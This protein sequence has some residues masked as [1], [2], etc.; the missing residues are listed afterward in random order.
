MNLDQIKTHFN[1][2]LWE[3]LYSIYVCNSFLAKSTNERK[4]IHWIKELLPVT[5]RFAR[6][7][8]L[9]RLPASPSLLFGWPCPMQMEQAGPAGA[10]LGLALLASGMFPKGMVYL[11]FRQIFKKGYSC[12]IWY[13]ILIL[14]KT[15]VIKKNKDSTPHPAVWIIIKRR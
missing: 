8:T 4:E 11:Y 15:F 2:N 1:F 6:S 7:F 10:W 13:Q 5:G 3:V 14:V 12:Y 9:K